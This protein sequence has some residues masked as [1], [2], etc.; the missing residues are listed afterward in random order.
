MT[1]L[2][3]AAVLCH[4]ILNSSILGLGRSTSGTDLFP[5]FWST[6][7]NSPPTT[8]F[9][10]IWQSL[11]DL[12][13]A[14]DLRA[15]A[16]G[17]SENMFSLWFVK[18]PTYSYLKWWNLIGMRSFTSSNVWNSF[19]NTA[20]HFMAFTITNRKPPSHAAAT[21]QERDTSL[22]S[23]ALES[24]YRVMGNQLKLSSKIP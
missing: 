11:W 2:L 9:S 3:S 8:S 10:D 16:K 4:P 7:T 17:V 18:I 12:R 22:G 24:A 15:A 1:T 19:H 23:W 13:G 20:C 5:I 6:D 14:C 21:A